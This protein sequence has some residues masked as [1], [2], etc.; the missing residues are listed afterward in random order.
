M[1]FI[2]YAEYGYTKYHI[3]FEFVLKIDTAFNL[4]DFVLIGRVP[5]GFCFREIA[6]SAQ[7]LVTSFAVYWTVMQGL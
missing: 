4:F 2:D 1:F 6:N 7:I 3:M 5:C